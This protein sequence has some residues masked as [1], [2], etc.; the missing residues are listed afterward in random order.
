MQSPLN[1]MP[2]SSIVSTTW[3][4]VWPGVCTIFTE[5][6]STSKIWLFSSLEIFILSGTSGHTSGASVRGYFQTLHSKKS[7]IWNKKDSM[8]LVPYTFIDQ[9]KHV[10]HTT[11]MIVMPMCNQNMINRWFFFGQKI[12]QAFFIFGYVWI[13]SIYQNSSEIR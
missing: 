6:P 5:A 12:F 4:V 13:S 11:D 1:K 2:S 8:Q 3:S 9:I 7:F 10:L